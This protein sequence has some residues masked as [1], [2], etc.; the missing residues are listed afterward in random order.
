MRFYKYADVAELA[1]SSPKRS[2]REIQ[3]GEDGAAVKI[4]QRPKLKRI[5]GT[6]R[7]TRSL[8]TSNKL[9]KYADVAELADALD[10][11]SSES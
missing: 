7:V 3:R 4:L 9:I 2:R 10:S 1:A 8:K 11:G 5:L 6:A